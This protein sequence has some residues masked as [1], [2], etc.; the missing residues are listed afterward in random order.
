MN[1]S[2]FISNYCTSIQGCLQGLYN[3][4]V[5]IAVVL[6][7]FVFLFGAFKNLLSV[8]PDIKMEGKSMMKNAIIGLVVIF[9]SGAVLYWINPFIFDPRIIIYGVKEIRINAVVT[10][11]STNVNV[12]GT[13]INIPTADLNLDLDPNTAKC[14]GEKRI[15]RTTHY[16]APIREEEPNKHRFLSNVTLQ[17]KAIIKDG[18]QLKVLNAATAKGILNEAK[19]QGR[20]LEICQ[21]GW[22]WSWIR[23]S[24][25][26]PSSCSSR[27]TRSSQ[28]ESVN[29]ENVIDN[30]KADQLIRE[31]ATIFQ[32]ALSG[33]YGPVIAGKTAAR[34]TNS[35]FFKRHHA[36]KILRC[37]DNNNQEVNCGIKN[38]IFVITDS[39]RGGKN[40]GRN[41]WLDLFAGIG[42]RARN[43][44][45]RQ[46]T[47]K[48]EVCIVG[49]VEI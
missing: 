42:E 49:Q 20:V 33:A 26:P 6:A 38:R 43:E 29:N 35:D 3:L 30:N 46:K 16:Y 22:V 7:F 24:G 28:S 13:N 18:D 10:S 45:A 11:T 47:D 8:V 31:R 15:I 21:I 39:G 41:N 40:W 2:D 25:S 37:L 5:A 23:V 27:I 19:R 44:F 12:N 9:L 48:A 32:G 17:G 14:I 1:I 4:G 36:V 34:D